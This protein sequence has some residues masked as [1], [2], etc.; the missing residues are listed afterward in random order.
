VAYKNAHGVSGNLQLPLP[1][2]NTAT[3]MQ[4]DPA[5]AAQLQAILSPGDWTYMQV[6]T[7]ALTEVVLV[8]Y[9]ATQNFTIARAEDGTSLNA[10]VTGAPA[11][12][13]LV[14]AAIATLVTP[15]T[16][17]IT[18][19][20]IA[21][22]ATSGDNVTITVPPP[23]F[24][25]DGIQISGDYPAL[26]FTITA[27]DTNCC[28]GSGG[29]GSSGIT[30]LYGYGIAAVTQ[31]GST[32]SITVPAPSFTSP[33]SS[34][35]IGGSWPN[36][37]FEASTSSSGTVTSVTAGAG[38]TVTGNP[39]V[40]PTIS[41]SATG[42]T[43]GTYGAMVVNA[44]GQITSLDSAF[45]PPS[46]I[47]ATAPLV[48]TRTGDTLALTIS[49]AEEGV[50]GVAP[51]A[52]STEPLDPTDHTSAVTPALL[53]SVVDALSGAA[54]SG[55]NNY[56]PA[57]T[58]NYSNIVS[59]SPVPVSLAAGQSA[60]VLANITMLNTSTPLTPVAFG[61]AVFNNSA[62]LIQGDQSA[63]QS[64]RSMS[65]ILQGP[66]TTSLVLTSTAVPSGASITASGLQVIVF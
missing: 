47:T 63:T 52:D 37:T 4:L 12:F 24:T 33:N 25:G 57:P 26:N 41:L 19:A 44:Y 7:G 50:P 56:A 59:A 27:D 64:Q 53:A 15:P 22:A 58:A 18:G 51:L 10:H 8:N 29:S 20:G 43:P 3:S 48:A 46:T 13:V 14:A 5:S 61:M 62:A 28:G 32:A 11:R 45:D 17:N 54:V 39:N 34:V 6:D 35:T 55:F 66:L 60:L 21:S 49:A 36:M 23:T 38:V 31:N 42:V 30:S 40:N 1:A 9:S 2:S 65:F 16:L